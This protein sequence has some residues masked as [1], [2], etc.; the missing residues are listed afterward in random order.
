MI[1]FRIK[2][3]AQ[4]AVIVSQFRLL[5]LRDVVDEALGGEEQSADGRHVAMIHDL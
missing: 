2:L 3:H 1:R 4:A 5:F